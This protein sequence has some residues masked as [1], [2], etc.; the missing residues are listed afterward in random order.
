MILADGSSLS[1]L[2]LTKVELKA[3][4]LT[5]THDIWVANIDLDAILGIDFLRKYGCEMMLYNGQYHLNLPSGATPCQNSRSSPVYRRAAA[6]KTV[7]MPP[8]YEV[9][10]PARFVDSLGEDKCGMMESSAR[11]LA[12]SQLLVARTLV[13]LRQESVHL[14]LLNL[15]EQ[16][17]TVHRQTNTLYLYHRIIHE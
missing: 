12:R 17:R 15:S 9:I 3:G 5:V 10:V 16:P 1:F 4:P 2:G 11:F 6:N 13:D 8:R 14:R 7:V